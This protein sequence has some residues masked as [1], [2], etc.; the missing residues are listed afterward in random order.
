MSVGATSR[1]SSNKSHSHSTLS[2]LHS[3][4]PLSAHISASRALS[5]SSSSSSSS[6]PSSSSST[7][8]ETEGKTTLQALVQDL[9]RAA[10]ASD[11]EKAVTALNKFPHMPAEPTILVYNVAIGTCVRA[12]QMGQAIGL[13]NQ[14]FES[15]KTHVVPNHLTYNLLVFGA[16]R[17]GDWT[18]AQNF[19]DEML[20]HKLRPDA[21]TYQ[22]LLMAC[23]KAKEKKMIGELLSQIDGPK[24][25]PIYTTAIAASARCGDWQGAL[26]L[27]RQ[28]KEEDGLEPGVGAYQAAM[29]ACSKPDP[30]RWTE[31]LDLLREMRS[32]GLPVGLTA[33]NTA[34]LCAGMAHETA[35]AQRLLDEMKTEGGREDGE[36]GKG[37]RLVPNN[38][39]YRGLIKSLAKTGDYEKCL[40]VLEEMGKEG[41]EPDLLLYTDAMEVFAR[42]QNPGATM[43]ILNQMKGAKQP[44]L[45]LYLAP[46]ID[47]DEAAERPVVEM[48]VKEVEKL[49]GL[50]V[51]EQGGEGGGM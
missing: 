30:A 47:A 46:L 27:L 7:A 26:A 3:T 1:Q 17:A 23:G 2:R 18:Q 48:F 4:P 19:R 15:Q 40:G 10:V 50:H 36:G 32:G 35:V 39:S 16:A 20:Q 22:G 24:L 11:A 33:Y 12:G 8:S 13:L 43:R 38:G 41:L 6:S 28:M 51:A 37:G 21:H 9:A 34:I 49:G 14:L 42:S 29:F 45:R 44:D 25:I 5:S 31:C